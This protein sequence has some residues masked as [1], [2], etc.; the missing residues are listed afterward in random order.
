VGPIILVLFGK[1]VRSDETGTAMVFLRHEWRIRRSHP[2]R[3]IKA[4]IVGIVQAMRAGQIGTLEGWVR[5]GREVEAMSRFLWANDHQIIDVEK[6]SVVSV[7]QDCK[8]G[9]AFVLG[10]QEPIALIASGG[11][12]V[13][14]P[15]AS[16]RCKENA[17]PVESVR[18]RNPHSQ[19]V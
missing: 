7:N 3:G 14:T 13:R 16:S 11:P 8:T 1:V 15:G 2:E 19:M 17:Q 18:S 9:T 10:H 12:A 4:I 5:I 6:L